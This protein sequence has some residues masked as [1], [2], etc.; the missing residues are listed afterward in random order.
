MFYQGHFVCVT[1]VCA[2][3]VESVETCS[4]DGSY[5]LVV[6]VGDWCVTVEVETRIVV[7]L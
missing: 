5:C 3:A 7:K 6:D 2:V 1:L 4:F